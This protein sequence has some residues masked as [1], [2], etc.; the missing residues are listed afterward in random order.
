MMQ[1]SDDY[2]LC[3]SCRERSKRE[4]LAYCKVCESYSRVPEKNAGHWCKKCREY[5][6]A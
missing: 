2:K 1:D 6:Y 3:T 5:D 4:D